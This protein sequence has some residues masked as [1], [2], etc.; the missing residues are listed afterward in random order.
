M[1]ALAIVAALSQCRKPDVEAV[2][3]TA[4]VRISCTIPVNKDGKTDFTNILENSTVNWS[5]GVESIYLAIP[6]ETAPQIVELTSEP[7]DKSKPTLTFTGSVQSG[8]LTDGT[9]DVWYFGNSKHTGISYIE[10]NVK[11]DI[12]TSINGAISAQSGS[13]SDL[14]KCHIAKATVTASVSEG[15]ATT[16]TFNGTFNNQIAIVRLGEESSKTSLLRGNAVIGTDYSL[17]YDGEKF[18]LAV[19][20]SAYANISVNPQTESYV[21]VFP[22]TNNNVELMS[23]SGKKVTFLNGINA[24]RMYTVGWEKYEGNNGY[25]YVDLGLPSGLKW[26][27]FNVGANTPEAYGDYF[28]WGEIAPKTYYGQNNSK[29]YW[30]EMGNISGNTTYDAATVNWGED[31]RIPTQGEMQ[32]L[33]N[34]CTWTWTQLN[35]VNGYN[36]TGTNGKS[37]FLPAAGSYDSGG[38]VSINEQGS[39]WTST[40]TTI[41]NNQRAYYLMFTSTSKMVLSNYRDNGRPIR[42]VSGRKFDIGEV[43]TAEVTSITDNSAV[44]GGYVTGNNAYV[45]EKGICWSTSESPTINDNKMACG[46]G[47]GGYTVTLTGLT[48][49]TVYYVRAYATNE[50]GTNYGSQ[51]RFNTTKTGSNGYAYDF[52]NMGSH[53]VDLGLPSGVLWSDCNIGAEWA[54]EQA[55]WPVN[56]YGNYFMWACNTSSQY[57]GEGNYPDYAKAVTINSEIDYSYNYS[58]DIRYDAATNLWGGNWRTPTA[59]DIDELVDNCTPERVIIKG[60]GQNGQEIDIVCMKFTS[61]KNSNSS[62]YFP[63]GGIYYDSSELDD[64]NDLG[65]YLTASIYNKRSCRDWILR[66]ASDCHRGWDLRWYGYSLRPVIGPK[67]Q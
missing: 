67:A 50:A 28:A 55:E 27:T 49:A 16:L 58:G 21:V 22:N 39:Y 66:T 38:G 10:E 32:E 33:I 57:F 3:S 36:V 44:C 4:K 17:Q 41:E 15:G 62:I 47:E 29:T 52:S 14:G 5:A 60:I 31:W 11:N 18:E 9:Y 42:P 30:K 45:T 25:E 43:T 26:A 40:P 2:D 65:Y 20:E 59:A 34:N 63:L 61:K 64:R 19:T 51:V 23:D 6:H 48:S 7:Q 8:L 35:D 46:Q 37:I 13:L 54:V 24:S 1:M 53:V 56:I 12:M